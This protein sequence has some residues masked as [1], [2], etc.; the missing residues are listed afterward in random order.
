MRTLQ[1]KLD[2]KRLRDDC[3]VRAPTARGYIRRRRTSRRALLSS[4][5]WIPG[6]QTG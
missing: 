6:Y 5:D 4:V 1:A 2:L 3:V